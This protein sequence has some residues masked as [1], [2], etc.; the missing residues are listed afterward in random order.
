M[1][2]RDKAINMLMKC[3]LYPSDAELAV[4]AII[5]AARE[6]VE[7]TKPEPIGRTMASM[8]AGPWFAI[9]DVLDKAQPKWQEGF[10]CAKVKAC[11]AIRECF[12]ERDGLRNSL[13]FVTGERDDLRECFAERDTLRARVAE[14][15]IILAASCI[16]PVN[17]IPTISNV[18]HKLM[19][20]PT[21]A[22]ILQAYESAGI[23]PEKWPWCAMDSNHSWNAYEQEPI[24]QTYFFSQGGRCF[25][26]TLPPVADWKQSKRRV[27]P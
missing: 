13:T 19:E 17:S 6:P 9:C 8:Y 27:V 26:L 24:R 21:Q 18:E 23:V 12:T 3:G 2:N 10:E 15:E 14:L 22:E 20:Q 4:D 1:T 16:A 5:A 7:E 11:N 25:G